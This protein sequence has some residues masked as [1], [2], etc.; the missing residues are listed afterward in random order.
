MAAAGCAASG[1]TFGDC[2][3]GFAEVH[4][5]CFLRNGEKTLASIAFD[6]GPTLYVHQGELRFDVDYDPK[7][8]IAKA[9]VDQSSSAF[10]ADALAA[11]SAVGDTS[12]LG[13]VFNLTCSDPEGTPQRDNCDAQ[14]PQTLAVYPFT[15]AD[16]PLAAVWSDPTLHGVCLRNGTEEQPNLSINGTSLDFHS[17]TALVGSLRKAYNA[18]SSRLRRVVNDRA[19]EDEGMR[20]QVLLDLGLTPAPA[21]DELADQCTRFDHAGFDFTQCPSDGTTA[22]TSK[23]VCYYTSSFRDIYGLAVNDSGKLV[24]DHATET[25]P[26]EASAVCPDTNAS[27]VAA[28]ASDPDFDLSTWIAPCLAEFA[29]LSSPAAQADALVRAYFGADGTY[30]MC[31][32]GKDIAQIRTLQSNSCMPD[33]WWGQQ[34]GSEALEAIEFGCQT[35]DG[36]CYADDGAFVGGIIGNARNVFEVSSTGNGFNLSRGNTSTW[37]GGVDAEGPVT[38]SSTQS[39]AYTFVEPAADGTQSVMHAFTDAQECGAYRDQTSD[40]TQYSAVRAE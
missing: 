3:L 39:E 35:P 14:G 22:D 27:V 24:V 13:G 25:Y 26:W 21:D 9:V 7:T 15:Q 8:G 28:Q 12:A 1:V 5:G 17:G 34:I 30:Q 36:R 37:D 6:T 16:R 23:Y 29:A 4:F 32:L 11:A 20:L 2:C 31:Q 18:L 40:V 33:I 10:D 19:G 38:C